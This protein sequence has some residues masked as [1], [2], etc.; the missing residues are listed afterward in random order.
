MK[1]SERNKAMAE[2]ADLCAARANRNDPRVLRAKV[3]A[4][5]GALRLAIGCL[6]HTDPPEKGWTADVIKKCKAA[7]AK[8][9]EGL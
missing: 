2:L 9:G 8:A 3:K 5:A 6:E 1:I 7:L 4:L